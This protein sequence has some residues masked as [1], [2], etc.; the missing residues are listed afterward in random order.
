MMRGQIIFSW[1]DGF[2]L[3]VPFFHRLKGIHHNRQR[4][5]IYRVEIEAGSLDVVEAAR[6]K[7]W[8][9]MVPAVLQGHQ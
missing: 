1:K 6:L 8:L 4:P 2:T 7:E 5:V 3:R 9:F